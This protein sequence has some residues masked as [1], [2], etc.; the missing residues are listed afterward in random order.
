[1]AG[2]IGYIT[3]YAARNDSFRAADLLEDAQRN[4]PMSRAVLNAYLSNLVEQGKLERMGRG[5]YGSTAKKNRFAPEPGE[6]AARLYRSMKQE[7]PLI[8]M[9]VYEGHWISP[10]M[11]NL[12]NNQAIYLEIEKSVSETVFHNLR[13]RGLTAFYRPY[14]TVMYNYVDLGNAPV[15][16]KNL[17]TESPLQ[18]FG[19]IQIPTLEKLLVDMYCDPDFFYLQGSE[20]WHIMHNAHRYSINTSKMLRYAARRSAAEEIKWIWEESVNDF[21]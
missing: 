1:M 5:V 6:K 19:E 20:Y 2:V 13:D 16:V 9:C 3:D 18:T 11:H 14:K 8:R 10:L 21:D 7:F 17:V 15:I 4:Y 12:A